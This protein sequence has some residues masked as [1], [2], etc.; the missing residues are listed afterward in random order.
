MDMKKTTSQ[1]SQPDQ[2]EKLLEDWCDVFAD[3]INVLA[4]KSAWKKNIW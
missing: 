2:T 1:T 4:A 3:I